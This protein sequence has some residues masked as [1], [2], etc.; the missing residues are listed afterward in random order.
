MGMLRRDSSSGPYA[1]TVFLGAFL[2]FQV[3]PI[4]AKYLLP[5]FGGV[6][7]VWTTCML[8]FQGLLLAGYGYAHVLASRMTPRTQRRVHAAALGASLLLLAF[9]AWRWGSPILPA[10]D[11][12]PQDAALPAVRL[13]LL[14]LMSVGLP[15]V[16]LSTTG[17]LLQAQFSRR[18]PG[19]SP[20]WLYTLSNAGSLA[21]LLS[22]PFVVE[23]LLTLAAQAWL[24]AAGYVIFAAGCAVCGWRK[25]GAQE[26]APRGEPAPAAARPP[27]RHY[28][29]WAGLAL[30]AC[31]MLLATT[32]RIT[33][34]IAVIPFLWLLPLSL[35]LLSFILCFSGERWYPRHGFLAAFGLAMLL[36]SW[37]LREEVAL[38]V[39]LQI[40][41][42][43][44]ILFVCCMVAHGELY[45]LKPAPRYLTAYYGMIALGGA[46][47]GVLVGVLAPWLFRGLWEYHVGL[48]VCCAVVLLALGADPVSWSRRLRWHRW[49]TEAL[50]C[51]F[52]IFLMG[53]V[54]EAGDGLAYAARN[55]YGTVRVREH[56]KS[57][58]RE[59]FC[60]LLNNATVHGLQF[61]DPAKRFLPVSYYCP[62]SGIGR[63]FA[64]P[65]GPLKDRPMAVGVA[66]LGV[67]MVG[68]Y[69][70]EGD[71]LRFYEINPLVIGLARGEGGY[72]DYLAASQGEVEI[73]PGDARLSMEREIRQSAP[74]LDVLVVDVFNGDSIP[75]HLLTREAW[76]IYLRRLRPEGLLILHIS[77][78]CLDLWP[79]T[80]RLAGHFGLDA[81]LIRN[82]LVKEKHYH[83]AYWV[84]ASRDTAYIAR[85]RQLD[86][87][88]N[89]PPRR[90]SL[91][92]DQFS[93]LL[94]ALF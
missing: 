62:E 94:E 33:Q 38:S 39:R 61:T 52:A 6:P 31:L 34:E 92:T 24:W 73:V 11:W 7:S 85:L 43:S 37:S 90:A 13:L 59:R 75:V 22:Y 42:A 67:G 76:E 49:A 74:P 63:V 66:G 80:R 70:R 68:A 19:R 55:F 12:K 46:L 17:P 5:W 41:A 40:P 69:A 47:G 35:Y 86:T 56:R 4:I 44:V 81:V 50:F 30:A 26:A 25:A 89:R 79:V 16:M 71:R 3:Q 60:T 64:D 83:T 72:F 20:Y 65:P 29:L 9:L 28:G 18:Y 32:N 15:F 58:P 51:L 48:F 77:N 23:P 82:P 88:L 8:C 93:N 78:R 87:A 1:V 45:R 36:A 84:I 53:Q 2:L 27:L 91:W 54:Q 21:A 10:A 57:E 14:L